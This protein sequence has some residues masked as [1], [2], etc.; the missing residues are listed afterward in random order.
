MAP[1]GL[2]VQSTADDLQD[3]S[4]CLGVQSTKDDLQDGHNNTRAQLAMEEVEG[5]EEEEGGGVL[6]APA[7]A[8]CH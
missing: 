5:E 1:R 3:G 2:G 8:G 4:K 7:P 6:C